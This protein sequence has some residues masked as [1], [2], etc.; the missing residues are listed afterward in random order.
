MRAT[1]TQGDMARHELWVELADRPGNLAALAGDLA[2]C[3]ANIVHLD[4]L[5]G[6]GDTVIDRLVV[7]VPDHRSGELMA[8][9]RRCGATLRSL[10]DDTTEPPAPPG[11]VVVRAASFSGH[12]A[13]PEPPVRRS[14]MT[15]ERL[16]ALSDGGLVRLRHLGAGDRRA[17]VAHH[18]RCSEA[19]RRH[20]RFLAAGVD[21][22]VDDDELVA[23]AAL[24]GGA[25]VGAARYELRDGGRRADLS[26]IVE[27]AHQRRGIGALLVSE[28]ATL[29]SNAGVGHVRAVA[30]GGGDGLARTLRRAGLD[31]AVRRDGDALVFEAVLADD[32][33]A[34]A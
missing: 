21:I 27:D 4:V 34:S 32:L 33:S 12:V 8:V 17:L 9:A 7:R 14:P 1:G 18:G 31:V 19:T 26:V 5:A 16:V 25:I 13:A 24:V 2:A 10:E 23:L 15:L 11:P 20:S 6:T 29:A 22:E 3:D 28:L 30:P